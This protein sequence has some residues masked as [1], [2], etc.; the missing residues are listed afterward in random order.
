M[1]ASN[2]KNSI[3]ELK[4]TLMAEGITAINI[5]TLNSCLQA[6]IQNNY[7]DDS[8]VR[9][10]IVALDYFK[11]SLP[12]YTI[13]QIDLINKLF[14]YSN[15]L[16]DL[17]G[18]CATPANTTTCAA[19]RAMQHM[20]KEP[21]DM[22]PEYDLTPE[23]IAASAGMIHKE[24]QM[25]PDART[26]TVTTYEHMADGT[27]KKINTEILTEPREDDIFANILGDSFAKDSSSPQLSV[28][29]L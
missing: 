16:L 21:G 4:M 26:K 6:A 11:D 17:N 20:N 23:K 29:D 8:E 22:N 1:D 2:F 12:Y 13:L 3:Q 19:P 15:I 28:D 25:D 24:I 27:L 7:V 18:G 14:L 5:S 10:L 9:A